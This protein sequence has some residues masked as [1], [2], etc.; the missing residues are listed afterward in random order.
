MVFNTPYVKRRRNI[1]ISGWIA[2]ALLIGL[3]PAICQAQSEDGAV[4]NSQDKTEESVLVGGNLDQ[5]KSPALRASANGAAKLSTGTTEGMSKSTFTAQP[6]PPAPQI[7]S[8]FQPQPRRQMLVPQNPTEDTFTKPFV[9]ELRGEGLT[10][11]PQQPPD[12]GTEAK[13]TFAT[14]KQD[15]QNQPLGPGSGMQP[16]NMQRGAGQPPYS[17]PNPSS[18]FG[19]PTGPPNVSSRFETPQAQPRPFAP[20][21]ANQDP[22]QPS[23]WIE[24]SNEQGQSSRN[25]NSLSTNQ[26]SYNPQLPTAAST[27]RRPQ[28]GDT[29]G[30]PPALPPIRPNNAVQNAY[31]TE[32]ASGPRGPSSIVQPTGFSQPVEVAKTGTDLAKSLIARFSVD[33]F[34]GP[35]PGKPVKLVEMLRQPISVEQRK[36]LIIQF[37]TTYYDWV[38]FVSE[39]ENE[40]LVSRIP[41]PTN[42]AEKAMLDVARAN[43]RNRVLAAKIQ[44][45]KS[46][47]KLVQFLPNWNSE[48][49]PIPNDLP[50]IQ[51]YKT[52]YEIYKSYQ[53][54]PA[55]LRG[56]DQ[57]LPDTLEL[58]VNRASAVELSQTAASRVLEAL[59]ARQSTTTHA[60]DCARQCRFLNQDLVAS[61]ISYNQAI[62]DYSLTV[63]RG[64]QTPEQIEAMLIAKPML[65]TNNIAQRFQ[66][67]T[68]Q[69]RRFNAEAGSLP[70]GSQPQNGFNGTSPPSLGGSRPVQQFPSSGQ[71]SG[72]ARQ[73]DS[74]PQS[75]MLGNGSNPAEIPRSGQSVLGG[76]VA[77]AT[78]VNA[79]SLG[80]RPGASGGAFGQPFPNQGN[81]GPTSATNGS[82]VRSA[83]SPFGPGIGPGR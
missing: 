10:E 59:A 67:A 2:N 6:L 23:Q 33:N 7:P 4:Q 60:I 69:Q 64:Y 82:G 68:E 28:V 13:G 22:D 29:F 39:Q 41:T 54:M 58:I 34:S 31:N 8:T 75:S 55:N 66:D 65:D 35:I 26:P 61:V 11:E 16:G 77:P 71:P 3:I 53:L 20:G 78:P 12:S 32:P 18:Q 80:A 51:K 38:M 46:Q 43:A 70:R 72:N 83:Q 36:P 57:M 1:S 42:T 63:A 30:S 81:Q 79:D 40:Q 47:S 27:N 25:G 73:F 5:Q 48:L 62:A 74:N 17:Q 19:Q 9:N 44:L 15:W 49:L 21:F 14:T 56:I 50:L 45:G 52:N 24:E 37:W 76:T